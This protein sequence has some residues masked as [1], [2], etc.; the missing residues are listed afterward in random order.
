MPLPTSSGSICCWTGKCCLKDYGG[1]ISKGLCFGNTLIRLFAKEQPFDPTH[2]QGRI[3]NMLRRFAPEYERSTDTEI[4]NHVPF[5]GD[6]HAVLPESADI[7]RQFLLQ[8]NAAIPAMIMSRRTL[9]NPLRVRD[10]C[11]MLV[12]VDLLDEAPPLSGCFQ[13]SRDARSELWIER[14]R[15]QLLIESTPSKAA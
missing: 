15:E 1:E 9:I 14:I 10:L 5:T 4:S 13:L 2:S 8:P 3:E 11:R 12:A 7:F 6:G